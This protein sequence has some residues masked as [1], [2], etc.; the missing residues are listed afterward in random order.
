MASLN[1]F[2]VA[3]RRARDTGCEIRLTS[4]GTPYNTTSRLP[5]FMSQLVRRLKDR[6]M[7]EKSEREQTAVVE[8]LKAC[9]ERN[10]LQDAPE[11]YQIRRK[12]GHQTFL[13]DLEQYLSAAKRARHDNMR[14]TVWKSYFDVFDAAKQ[15]SEAEV[16]GSQ[17]QVN[18]QKFCHSIHSQGKY[19]DMRGE[20]TNNYIHS[21]YVLSGHA[22]E[23][24]KQ[25]KSKLKDM[26]ARTGIP[27]EEVL[28]LIEA[29]HDISPSHAKTES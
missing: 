18:F 16:S 26:K 19:N 2:V 8:S 3:C 6:C 17:R 10:N 5:R 13:E 20:L 22:P 25:N 24:I 4:D 29:Y 28:P 23:G 21:A 27:A 7:P 15:S 1:D 12:S 11:G 9:I 14:P